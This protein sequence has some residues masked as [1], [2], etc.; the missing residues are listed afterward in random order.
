MA[1]QLTAFRQ[2]ANSESDNES[3]VNSSFARNIGAL[4]ERTEY[5]RC[6]SGEDVEAMYRLRYKAYRLHGFLAESSDKMMSDVLDDSPNCYLFGIFIDNE[7]AS[8]VR[9]HHVTQAEPYGPMMSTFGDVMRP[10]LLRGESFINPTLLAAEPF[11]QSEKRGLPY[12]TL[13]LG[14]IASVYFDATSC[15]GVVRDEH[16]AFYRRVFGAVQLG[17]PRPYPPFTVPVTLQ[18]ANCA[19][20]RNRILQRFPFFRSTPMEQR[21]LFSRPVRGELAPLTILPTAKYYREAA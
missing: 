21:M 17:Q 4:L 12:L 2:A 18:D 19:V 20:N 16:T 13:R 10:R 5:R 9:I 6:E 11:M 14:L 8:T 3:A 15:V 7:L 1:V